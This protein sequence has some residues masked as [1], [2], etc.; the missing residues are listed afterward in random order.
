MT[1]FVTFLVSASVCL[2]AFSCTD[3]MDEFQRTEIKTR[4][5]QSYLDEIGKFPFEN[6]IP[7]TETELSRTDEPARYMRNP[8]VNTGS[9]GWGYYILSHRSKNK[10]SKTIIDN[11]PPADV[12][13]VIWPGALV[14]GRSVRD[15]KPALIPIYDKRKPGRISLNVVSGDSICFWRDI[16][17]FSASDVTQTM[18]D[19]LAPYTAG[20]PANTNFSHHIVH[21]KEEM[22]YYLNMDTGTFDATTKGDFSGIG[23]EKQTSKVMVKLRQTFFTMVYDQPNLR[24]VF[25]NDITVEELQRYSGSDNPVA[26]VSSV[27]YGRYFILL[28]E[29]D[30]TESLLNAAVGDA[31]EEPQTRATEP[32]SALARNVFSRVKVVMTQIG[33]NPE[34]GLAAITGDPEKIREFIV[35]GA[36]FSR[37]NVGEI[38]D[39][40][41]N[42]LCNN[43][44]LPVYRHMDTTYDVVEYF[45]EPKINDV[46]ITIRS[47][48]NLPLVQTG[49]NGH[50][51]KKSHFTCYPLRVTVYDERN[52]AVKRL[53]EFDPGLSIITSCGVRTQR[54]YNHAF[55]LGVLGENT[56]YKIVMES[57]VFFYNRRTWSKNDKNSR[58]TWE[59]RT[60]PLRVEFRYNVQTQRWE[61]RY[62]SASTPA[63]FG[64]ISLYDNLCWCNLQFHIDFDFCANHI[65]Y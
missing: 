44:T 4:E 64:D 46:T 26:Y 36:V 38:M 23:W 32:V 42:Y 35:K 8:D 16:D 51:S 22:A 33:G 53:P 1:K 30:C 47:I 55:N 29:S 41:V 50:V 15:G 39:Y 57:S 40:R 37:D 17:T 31:Y 56:K 13:G 10:Q 3:E 20:F 21:S 54:Y 49:G 11:I 7:E 5:L 58:S 34:Q 27:S 9:G 60:Y 48:R 45:E 43:Q 59:S 12:A 52:N 2:I 24:D 28:Y 6:I 14:Q 63:A 61:A 18:N 25:T 62:G 19:I 65:Y